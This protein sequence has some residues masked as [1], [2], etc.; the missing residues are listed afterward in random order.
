MRLSYP[1]TVAAILSTLAVMVTQ[2]CFLNLLAVP[3]I[4]YVFE[5]QQPDGTVFKTRIRGDEYFNWRETIDHQVIILNRKTGYYEYAI[6]KTE[7][8]Q[9]SLAPS[10]RVVGKRVVNQSMR[11][12]RGRT[13]SKEDLKRLRQAAVKKRGEFFSQ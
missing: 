8:G 12:W 5:T 6:I 11:I 3:A 1:K 9:E 2:I 10:G 7:N 4:P 13:V